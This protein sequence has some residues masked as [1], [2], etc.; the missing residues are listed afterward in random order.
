MEPPPTLLG[1][2][3]FVLHKVAVAA[4][5]AVAEGLAAETGLSLWRF[6]ALA[7]LADHGPAAQ[8]ELGDSLGLDPSDMARLMDGLVEDGLAERDRD[9]GDRRRYRASLTDAGRAALDRGRA[10]VA[11]VEERTLA[12]LTAAERSGLRALAG[13]IL[14]GETAAEQTAA[15]QPVTEQTVTEEAAAEDAAAEGTVRQRPE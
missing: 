2:T 7:A 13:K 8:R 5:R 3:T 1:I 15:E 10:V 9:P 11:A 4:R 6:A 14:T 12:P